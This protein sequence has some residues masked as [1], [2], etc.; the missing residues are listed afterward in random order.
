MNDN[1]YEQEQLPPIG[2]TVVVTE[3]YHL[4][5]NGKRWV[6]ERGGV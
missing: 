4:A 3:E 2:A 5:R 6:D 1:W